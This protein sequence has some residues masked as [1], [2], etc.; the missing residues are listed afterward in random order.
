MATP[1][2]GPRSP[3]TLLRLLCL[4]TLGVL[5]GVGIGP[6]VAVG[7]DPPLASAKVARL[8]LER[9][10]AHGYEITTVERGQPAVQRSSRGYRVGFRSGTAGTR[11]VPKY[12]VQDG[13]WVA[14]G[15]ADAPIHN[16]S[17]QFEVRGYDPD[18]L[19]ASLESGAHPPKPTR[20]VFTRLGAKGKIDQERVEGTE[21][22]VH[23][24]ERRAG[25]DV[26][27]LVTQRSGPAK[28]IV[29]VAG[30]SLVE[31]GG[32]LH[33]IVSGRVLYAYTYE[34][35]GARVE[36]VLCVEYSVRNNGLNWENAEPIDPREVEDDV[37]W[38]IAEAE[39]L[40]RARPDPREEADPAT[41]PPDPAAGT[42]APPPAAAPDPKAPSPGA[43]PSAASPGP[44]PAAH[45]TDGG[46]YARAV[47]LLVQV[48]GVQRELL[49]LRAQL[50]AGVVAMEEERELLRS[51]RRTLELLGPGHADA[52]FYRQWQ[53]E[54][55]AKIGELEAERDALLARA[56]RSWADLREALNEALADPAADADL[57][58]DLEGLRADLGRRA[59]IGSLELLLAAGQ[60]AEFRRRLPAALADPHLAERALE[61]QALDLIDRGKTAEALYALRVARDRHPDNETFAYLLD[62]VET[63]YLNLIAGQAVGDA[64]RLRLA[65]EEYTAGAEDSVLWQA[66][67]SGLKRTLHAATGRLAKR[68]AV[69]ASGVDQA[70][71]TQ[72]G[73]ELMLR[74]RRQGLSLDEIQGLDFYGLR[75]WLITIAPDRPRP[76]DETVEN[77]SLALEVAFAHRDVK[78]L[79][80]RDKVLMQVDLE[81]STLDQESFEEA[82]WESGLD[83][84]SAKNVLLI[85]G[86]FAQVRGAGMLTRF[87]QRIG[88]GGRAAA[89]AT[90]EAASLTV[91]E[92]VYARPFMKELAR[93]VGESRAGAVL[94]EGQHALRALRYDTPLLVRGTTAVT[95]FTANMAAHWLLIEGLGHLGHEV[96]GEY[97]R[98]AGELAA[99][100]VGV[101][102]TGSVGRLQQRWT[103]SQEALAIARARWQ[104]V[105]AV[106]GSARAPIHAAAA[107]LAGGRTL[108][109]AE[110]ATLQTAL[111]RAEEAAATARA[112]TAQAG[113][114]G[115]AAPGAAAPG[116][117]APGAGGS[118][119]TATDAALVRAAAEEA[120]SLAATAR[121]TLAGKPDRA[122]AASKAAR[123]IGAEV[124]EAARVVEEAEQH[125]ALVL[126]R[127][128]RNPAARPLGRPPPPGGVV[129]EGGARLRGLRPPEPLFPHARPPGARAPLRAPPARARAQ[130]PNPATP[131]A[132]PPRPPA[133]PPPAPATVAELEAQAAALMRAERFDDAAALL[134]TA[135]RRL[136][137]G[138]DALAR[139]AAALEEARS[140]A[141]TLRVRARRAAL[142]RIARAAAE[143]D[144]ALQ[145]FTA[146]ARA[147]IESVPK[148]RM[149]PV[150][151]AGGAL[152]IDDA[153]GD[154][155]A[156][157]KPA[158]RTGVPGVQ[159]DG[160][161][162]AELL[163]HRLARR[164][165]LRV[166]HVEPMVLDGEAGVLVRWIPDTTNLQTLS[167]GARL[168]LKGQ[169]AEFRPL[170]VVTGNY[171]IHLE[172]F[173]VDRAGRVWSI[174]AGMSYL[175]T[176]EYPVS[177]WSSRWG[178]T[179]RELDD[180]DAVVNWARW[181]RDWYRE[182]GRNG[183]NPWHE[184]A[185]RLEEMLA[186]RDMTRAATRLVELGDEE[187]ATLVHGVVR[188]AK[189]PAPA[190][191]ILRTLVA[192]RQ[193]L[194]ALL[195]EQ[196]AGALPAR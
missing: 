179:F 124:Q 55:E 4:G 120:E 2:H 86:P 67:S 177:I 34:R 44:P 53:A 26:E 54:I 196:W 22:R 100:V 64:A 95:G 71:M 172:N 145:P 183:G 178:H 66:F 132:S 110:R 111:T 83:M 33:P 156:V 45:A 130:A 58:A 76:A 143:A 43:D 46:P 97:G 85:F 165:G 195:N 187:L 7:E 27:R 30:T 142:P 38:A 10:Q 63:A 163:H 40:G 93:R 88:G 140:A 5:A 186:G 128:P 62:G 123:K 141:R 3:R 137:A 161:L 168:A 84:V 107:T 194:P 174:D 91:Q 98:L 114:A 184:A 42:D 37:F 12:K 152:R 162:I 171:D 19:P 21:A 73:I 188:H 70:A 48:G 77:L 1:F 170:Q 109:A 24:R 193:H 96:G 78:R 23:Q 94:R 74:L 57:R 29:G 60:H 89:G 41:G 139:V 52:G 17:G 72:V 87:A 56:E 158:G 105:E 159:E 25:A 80:A 59:Q 119:A 148:S 149:T 13:E 115:A 147:Y 191:E 166:P 155:L 175:T 50:R 121:A 6:L 103:R 82:W 28:R 190:G 47:D 182:S 75:E 65:W 144:E 81:R 61:L 32:P 135:V 35:F 99:A 51:A 154:P 108:G 133:A 169:V 102:G 16:A 15:T 180:A 69:H 14:D 122:A 136:G 101:P 113:R 11:P 106:L 153:M 173:K 131:P 134:H 185:A 167:P 112:A 8:L 39:G 90:G 92:W 181:L 127:G 129:A 151:G 9:A 189:D 157:W 68:E 176:P 150:G 125:L 31:R 20:F 117:A 146:E 126:E 18:K 138:D 49:Y 36:R 104:Q 192:R 164:L 160:Q 118:A 116:A 79:R